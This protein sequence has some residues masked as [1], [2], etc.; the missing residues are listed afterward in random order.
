MFRVNLE[1]YKES[2]PYFPLFDIL[3]KDLD[4]N[5]EAF[6]K[7]VGISPSSYR[8]AR[9]I[10]QNIG[11]KIIEQLCNALKYKKTSN[12][13]VEEL[14]EL[15]NKVYFDMYYKIFK[16]FEKDLEEIENLINENY[17]LKPILVLLKLFLLAN[18]KIDVREYKI[19]NLDE[20]N[21]LKKYTVFFNEDLLEIMDIL[22][23]VFE[24]HIPEEIMMKTYKN[25]LAYYSLASRLCDDKRYVESLFI[26]KKAEE[27]LVREKNY[28]R[29][30]YLNVKMMYCL[31]SIH[32]YQECYDLASMQLLTLQSFVDTDFEFMHTIRNLAICC[33]PLKKYKYIS[34]LLMEQ[35]NISMVELCCLLVSKFKISLIDYNKLYETYYNMMD[36]NDKKTLLIL[37]EYLKNSDKKELKS[38]NLGK[39]TEVFVFVLKRTQIE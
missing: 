7:E 8:K 6:L 29:L 10:E 33:L 5:K 31:N 13:F 36:N 21:E 20:Y 4:I 28:K 14:E 15:F 3:L 34:D 32:S 38:I 30:L 9:T 19:N 23:L 27:V 16:S 17:I 26:S 1:M 11:D 12:L 24:Q 37:D 39:W 2:K 25:S 35:A 18:S 22:A